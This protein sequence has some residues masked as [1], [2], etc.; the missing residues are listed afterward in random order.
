[1]ATHPPPRTPSAPGAPADHA[2]ALRRS[3]PLYWALVLTMLTGL[4][5][6]AL[7]MLQGVLL[8][9]F[10]AALFAAAVSGPSA[11][12]ERM[13]VP[14]GIAVL[15]VY[16]LAAGVLFGIGY[17]VV[18]NAVAQVATAAD[19]LP[20]YGERFEGI[21]QRYEALREDYP[22]LKPFDEQF[23]GVRDQVIDG[24]T[25]RLLN[26]PTRLFSLFIDTLSVFVISVMLVT[27]RERI[28][29][30]ILSLTHPSHRDETRTVLTRIWQRL[31]HY[32]RAK[33]IVMVII[34][35]ITYLGLLLIGVPYPV[36]LAIIVAL[37][38]LI[39]RAG[40]W[41]ARI[42]LLT[43]ALL[44]GW[45][46]FGLTFGLSIIVENLK[47]LV[48]SPF[49]EGDQLDIHPLLV[50]ISV[51]IGAAMFG[52]AGA[53]VAVPAAA[54]LEVVFQEVIL[55][56]RKRQL[57]GAEEELRAEVLGTSATGAGSGAQP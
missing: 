20:G 2:D 33:L 18:P 22:T 25:A 53:F 40:P 30:L 3:L 47:G 29:T 24:A 14:R 35:G 6:V 39:P 49:V 8:L 36:M 41:M 11:R 38:Q 13:G 51:L 10:I 32:L 52:A 5:L 26:L 56:W 42:P 48:I 54:A 23:A 45:M 12:M 15:L 43:I 31:G 55:P 4:F 19:D 21:Q 50:F 1:M 57:Q 9:I 28:L 37:G 46:T 44:E 7:W 27:N 16:L 34:G 17:L